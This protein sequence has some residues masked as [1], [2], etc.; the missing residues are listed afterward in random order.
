MVKKNGAIVFS[1]DPIDMDSIIDQFSKI[2]DAEI[3][4]C[5]TS[6]SKLWITME[7]PKEEST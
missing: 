1:A 2:F 5:Q 3:I 6:Y 7:E 4:H